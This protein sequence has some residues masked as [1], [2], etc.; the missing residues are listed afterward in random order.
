MDL[1]LFFFFLGGGCPY[2][3][4]SWVETKR[5]NRS[6]S[7][8]R[9]LSGKLTHKWKANVND[10]NTAKLNKRYQNHLSNTL[11]QNPCQMSQCTKEQCRQSHFGCHFKK[12]WKKSISIIFFVIIFLKVFTV[13]LKKIKGRDRW[14]NTPSKCIAKRIRRKKKRLKRKKKPNKQTTNQFCL[15]R[16]HYCMQYS[17]VQNKIKKKKKRQ[18]NKRWSCG[19]KS[20]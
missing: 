6:V 8:R 20:N 1:F 2:Y 4:L 10:N 9:D 14:Y 12:H 15:Q 16:K 13:F 11:V 7:V 5:I 17:T 19:E 3:L 18:T